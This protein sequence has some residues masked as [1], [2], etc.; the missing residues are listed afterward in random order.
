MDPHH[1]WNLDLDA[2]PHQSEKQDT[3]THQSEKVEG[4]FW[5]IGG[6]KSGK[7]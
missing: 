2:H 3:Y 1:F 7:K 6:S 5:S 4:S